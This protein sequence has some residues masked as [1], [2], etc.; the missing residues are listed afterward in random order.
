MS[1]EGTNLF[2][3]WDVSFWKMQIGLMSVKY[4]FFGFE[5]FV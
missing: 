4:Q 1:T 2:V 3:S 5:K